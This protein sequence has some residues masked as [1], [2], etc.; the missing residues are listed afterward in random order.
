MRKSERRILSRTLSQQPDV[1]WPSACQHFINQLWS[2]ASPGQQSALVNTAAYQ[3]QYPHRRVR[4]G[5]Q[6]RVSARARLGGLAGAGCVCVG[7]AAG[8]GR[9]RGLG[10]GRGGVPRPAPSSHPALAALPPRA[11]G[12]APAARPA[13]AAAQHPGHQLLAGGAAGGGTA[14][15]GVAGR[16]RLG[17]GGGV[18]AGPAQPGGGGHVRQDAVGA[19]GAGGGAVL[20]R[21]QL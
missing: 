20:V 14:G 19:G 3:L 13:A 9:G 8:R 16:Q 1:N 5:G 21:R 2:T 10:G 11:P 7:G 15:L 12:A 17:L 18:A 6:P 4:H